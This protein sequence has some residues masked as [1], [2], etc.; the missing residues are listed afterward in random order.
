[1]DDHQTE[2]LHIVSWCVARQGDVIQLVRQVL[3][4]AA[5][6]LEDFLFLVVASI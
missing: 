1:M 3:H 6:G 2:R 4:C 5:E